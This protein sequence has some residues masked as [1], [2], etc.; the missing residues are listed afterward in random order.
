MLVNVEVITREVIDGIPKAI[1]HDIDVELPINSFEEIT[2]EFMSIEKSDEMIIKCVE[3]QFG[4]EVVKV[5]GAWEWK[6]LLH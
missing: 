1:T 3:E 5:E 4:L 6:S 2:E